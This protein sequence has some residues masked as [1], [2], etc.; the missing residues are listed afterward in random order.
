MLQARTAVR[1]ARIL[2]MLLAGVCVLAQ[3]ERLS[4]LTFHD[5]MRDGGKRFDPGSNDLGKGKN[6]ETMRSMESLV[7]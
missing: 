1:G 7:G 4:Q 5:G 2:T 3:L 6:C